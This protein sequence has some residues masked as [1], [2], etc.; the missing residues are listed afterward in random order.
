MVFVFG[1]KMLQY[2]FETLDGKT[3]CLKIILLDNSFVNKWKIYF[4]NILRKVDNWHVIRC[5]T[6]EKYKSVEQVKEYINGLILTYDFLIKNNMGDYTNDVKILN[7][8]KLRP[9]AINQNNLNVWHRHFT[10]LELFYSTK[11]YQVSTDVDP[12][13]VKDSI[14]NLNRF[15][16]LLEGVTYCKCSRRL[17]IPDSP[18][19]AIQFTNANQTNDNK[20]MVWSELQKIE[21][22]MFDWR[23]NDYEH[24]VW[25]NED[26]LGKDQI[27]A[28]LDHDD[29]TQDDVTGNLTMTPSI[30]LDPYKLFSKVLNNSEFRKESIFSGKTLDRYP[31]GD[32]VEYDLDYESLLGAKVKFIKLD[33]KIIWKEYESLL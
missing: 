20:M 13:L 19:Y 18:Q 29:L 15:V 8:L 32:I 3:K 21:P 30:M 24:T 11:N 33:C 2:E 9:E 10:S 26:I 23:Y 6:N 4:E 22:G 5:A 28:W 31:L 14:H 7:K 25:L 27:K 1:V 12:K 16:H 17:A